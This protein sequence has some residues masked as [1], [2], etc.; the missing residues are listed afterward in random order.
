[1]MKINFIGA[2]K[3]GRNIAKQIAINKAATVQGICNSRSGVDAVN[4]IGQGSIYKSINALPPADLTFITTPDDDIQTCCEKLAESNNLRKGSIV[5]HCSGVLTSDRLVSVKKKSCSVA[6]AHPFRSFIKENAFQ[7]GNAHCTIEGDQDAVKTL[8]Q[9]FSVIGY[10][11]YPIDRNKKIIYHAASIFASNYLVTLY[12]SA[13][14][15]LKEAEI[16]D[17]TAVKM[18]INLMKN[19]LENIETTQSAE[20]SLTGPIKRGDLNTV[21]EHLR[22]LSKIELSELYKKL[23]L[24]TLKI[25]NLSALEKEKMKKILSILS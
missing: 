11:V 16:E 2:G 10:L 14:S 6:S 19:T 21:S 8:T 3:L 18:T 12:K 15:C 24:I 23:G 13:L 4:F 9:L 25:T 22:V 1:M 20:K 17:I 7:S 5:A